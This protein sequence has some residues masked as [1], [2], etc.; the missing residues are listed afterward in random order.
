MT[1]FRI[2]AALA[3]LAPVFA[4]CQ[5]AGTETVMVESADARVEPMALMAETGL[6]KL[7]AAMAEAV[8]DGVVP[9]VAYLLVQDDR[10]VA[11]GLHGVRSI[12]VGDPVGEDTIYRI[13]SMTK[14]VT[15][16]AMMILYDEGAWALDDPITKFLPELEGLKVASGVDE[17]GAPILVPAERAPTMLEL[18]SHTAGFGYG[19]GPGDPVNEAFIERQVLASPDLETMLDKVAEIPLLFQPGQDW[20]YSVAVDLQGLIVERISGQ[21]FGDFLDARVFAP[22]GMTDTGFYVPDADRGRLSDVI[23][24]DPES[25]Q[26]FVV[27]DAEV[28]FSTAFREGAPGME[29]GGGGLVSTMQDYAR[30]AQMLLNDGEL[31]GV[32]LLQPETVEL[33]RTNVLGPNMRLFSDGSFG[34]FNTTALGFGLDFGVIIDGEAMGWGAPTGTYFWGGAAGTWFWID[35][36]NDLYFIG[37]IQRFGETPVDFRATS[38]KLVYDALKN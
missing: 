24:L 36:V 10:I 17:A 22:L 16:V 32:R 5:T 4:A 20:A 18:M 7:D 26:T 34:E 30:F 3:A 6:E 2:V 27:Q 31:D 19:L 12:E 25:G 38:S 9:G 28:G 29:S 33:M 14:P 23:A 35:P 1:S 21:S 15:G 37:M 8:E 11:E 13:Y